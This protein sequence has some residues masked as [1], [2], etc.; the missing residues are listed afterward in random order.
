MQSFKP[1][2]EIQNNKTFEKFY[3][4]YDDVPEDEIEF[5]EI[6]LNCMRRLQILRYIDEQY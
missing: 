3:N 6:K 1:N 2:N 5:E 4:I